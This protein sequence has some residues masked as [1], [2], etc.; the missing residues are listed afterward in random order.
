M[1]AAITA[2]QQLEGAVRKADP[3]LDELSAGSRTPD[4]GLLAKSQLPQC[5]AMMKEP[6][7]CDE[8]D[9]QQHEG[10]RG[11]NF[12]ATSNSLNYRKHSIAQV[13]VSET[14]PA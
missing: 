11:P 9:S 14:W 12:A 10:S 4:V 8:E 13:P 2:L 1:G 5:T 7:Y 3:R 6:L